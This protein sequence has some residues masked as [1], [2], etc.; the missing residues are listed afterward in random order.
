MNGVFALA[1]RA[2]HD[3]RRDWP[4]D[5]IHASMRDERCP[6]QVGPQACQLAFND[7][8]WRPEAN[9]QAI[10][11]GVGDDVRPQVIIADGFA[12]A[13]RLEVCEQLSH[14][15]QD[16]E[17]PR[18]QRS[19]QKLPVQSAH[20]EVKSRERIGHFLAGAEVARR[21]GSR[22]EAVRNPSRR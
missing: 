13:L 15:L 10:D 19:G 5:S 14:R 7:L 18:P 9:H 4:L 12:T 21:W 6:R 17:R 1:V 3:D 8:G 22:L 11:L 20:R 2:G 16:G